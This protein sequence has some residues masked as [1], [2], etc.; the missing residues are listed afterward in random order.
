MKHQFRF[1]SIAL[2]SA[3]TA[4]CAN[5]S[6]GSLFSHYSAQNKEIYQAV[7]SGDYSTAQQELP[8][9]VAGDILD[10][11]EKGRINLL[12]QKYPESKSSLELADQAVKD[13]QSKAVISVSDSATSVG[14]L[15]VNDNI[16]EYVPADYELGFLHLYL[17]LNYLKKNDL[18]GA[19][20]EMRRANQVQEQA[21]K[22]REAELESAASDAK[23]QGLSANVGSILANYPDAGKKLQSVQNAYLMFLSGLLY[24]ASND[25]NS[26]YV[27]YRRALAIMPDNQEIIDRT[28][29]TAARLGMR[30]DLAT[31]KK[32]YKQ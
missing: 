1:A 32:R 18:E 30:Q 21:K 24:E 14:A 22:Q 28:M 26:A 11:F 3:L 8:D 13:Q 9:Y 23:S 10:N 19:V 2:L 6:A 27:D 20:I 29:A 7:K 4:G 15:A 17:G 31:L 25:L 5:M 16:T 12:D